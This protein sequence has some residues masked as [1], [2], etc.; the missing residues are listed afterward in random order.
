MT[1]HRI[2]VTLYKLPQ[3]LNGDLDEML[4]PL[5]L[6]DQTARLEEQNG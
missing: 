6:A 4:N 5:I 1:D 2:N 3:F